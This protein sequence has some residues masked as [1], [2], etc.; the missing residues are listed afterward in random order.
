L[1]PRCAPIDLRSD[2]CALRRLT[3]LLRQGGF[4]VVHTHCAKAGALGRLAAHRSD[5]PRIVHTYHGFPSTNSSRRPA[6]VR[7]WPSSAAS[8]G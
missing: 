5:V 4:D 7:T 8:A 6:D 1:S 2:A 3:V